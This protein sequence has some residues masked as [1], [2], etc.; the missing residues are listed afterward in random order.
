LET[1]LAVGCVLDNLEHD[2]DRRDCFRDWRMLLG[3]WDAYGSKLY[4]SETIQQGL[5]ILRFTVGKRELYA[6]VMFHED[7]LDEVQGPGTSNF[8]LPRFLHANDP[9]GC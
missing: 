2:K 4:T 8:I 6:V 9:F 7:E 1:L 5:Y 3:A